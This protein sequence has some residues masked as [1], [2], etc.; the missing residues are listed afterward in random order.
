[1]AYFTKDNALQFAV[2]AVETRKNLK[3]ERRLTL[4]ALRSPS[5]DFRQELLT[6]TRAQIRIISNRIDKE[7]EKPSLDH[8]ALSALAANLAT[9]E[10]IEQKFSMRAGPGNLKP[11]ATRSSRSSK[12]VSMDDASA[13]IP[14][15]E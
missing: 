8:K 15:A 11:T 3:E 9:L 10:G 5:E 14:A 13:D 2:K 4:E 7:L 1:M 6:R 12:V